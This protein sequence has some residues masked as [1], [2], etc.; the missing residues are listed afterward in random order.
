MSQKFAKHAIKTI[1]K[2]PS[3]PE[4]PCVKLQFFNTLKDF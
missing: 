2:H 1:K 3:Y 4:F